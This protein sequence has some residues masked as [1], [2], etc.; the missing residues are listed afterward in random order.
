MERCP[1]CGETS[2]LPATRACVDRLDAASRSYDD[3]AREFAIDRFTC[4][5]HNA[6]DCPEC[7]HL[8]RPVTYCAGRGFAVS[9]CRTLAEWDDAVAHPRRRPADMTLADIRSAVERLRFTKVPPFQSRFP[10]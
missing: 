1:R 6:L 7:R 4:W 8:V 3:A 5:K 2:H 9:L 10:Q